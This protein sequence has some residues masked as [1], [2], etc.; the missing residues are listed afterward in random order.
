MTIVEIA[1]E[2]APFSKTGG[3]GDVLGALPRELAK[4]GQRVLLFLPRYADMDTS[5]LIL[6][7][8]HLQSSVQLGKKRIPIFLDTAKE[9]RSKLE[10]YFV[11]NDDYFSRPGMYQN[12]STG[13]DFPDNAERFAFFVLAVMTAVK[14]LGVQPDVF[15]V[16]DWQA[17]MLPVYLKTNYTNDPVLSRARS[18]LTIHNMAYQGSFPPETFPLLGLPESYFY[19][20]GPLEYY[21]QVNFLKAGILFADKI[22]TVSKTYAQEIQSSAEL[23]A[24]LDGVLSQRSADI[25]G[26]LNG[27]DYT[28]WSPSRDKVIPYTY[29]PANLSGKQKD[30][31]EL[32]YTL[33]LP[34]RSKA[35]V[36]GIIS[37]LVEQ[38][39]LDLIAKAA[40]QLLARDI[41]LLVL[42]SGEERYQKL[43]LDLQERYPDKVRVFIAF[44][45]ILS[46][47][48]EAAS[49]LFLMP[50]RFEPCG[51]NQ[52]Y[53]LKYGTVP[54]V[55]KIGG[56]ADTVVDY[57]ESTG[58]G[59]GFVFTAYTPEAML[60]AV[61][62]AI[63]AFQKRK[64]WITLMKQGMRQNFS[65]DASS[66]QYVQL[67]TDLKKS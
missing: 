48:I 59:T 11:G 27:V 66:R 35:P 65:W 46:H 3:L 54:I 41:Q 53:S 58:K 30:K 20:T 6:Q 4:Q 19:A 23:G 47:R 16:H 29:Y 49:D 28:V 25:T 43:F 50:S 21:N 67:F 61:D 1:S 31:I 36:I 44:D 22:T 63:A 2:A 7:R 60:T 10:Y 40:D 26:I 45:T 51:L 24:G 5:S 33:K 13:Q 12:P 34:H 55:H 17:A 8:T 15:H 42:G 39:G 9:K 37:R 14:E 56:L 32:L 64:Q 52:L 18:V 62:R 38:K 57:N